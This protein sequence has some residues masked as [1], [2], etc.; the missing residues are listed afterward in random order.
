MGP[1]FRG[2]GTTKKSTFWRKSR[3]LQFPH[4]QEFLEQPNFPPGEKNSRIPELKEKTQTKNSTFW[5][6]CGKILKNWNKSQTFMELV[7]VQ[8]IT[9]LTNFHPPNPP[10]TEKKKKKKKK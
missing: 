1:L 6:F 7:Y 9:K 8:K 10:K 3:V 5:Y 2:K 4:W